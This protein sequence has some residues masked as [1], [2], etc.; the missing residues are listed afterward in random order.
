MNW[1]TFG[2][3]VPENQQKT[4]EA[5]INKQIEKQKT[6]FPTRKKVLSA[7]DKH[8]SQ[9][10]KGHN[11]KPIDPEAL[12]FQILELPSLKAQRAEWEDAGAGSDE[13]DAADVGH[14]AGAGCCAV[15]G[16]VPEF[17]EVIWKVH[18]SRSCHESS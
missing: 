7:A 4:L 2:T 13:R 6:L 1:T 9:C 12:E 3:E 11:G 17:L 14:G 15:A 18:V 10:L 5:A 16:V 8:L